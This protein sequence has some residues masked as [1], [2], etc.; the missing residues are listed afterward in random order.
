MIILSIVIEMQSQLTDPFDFINF[1]EC[2]VNRGTEDL[3]NRSHSRFA[4]HFQKGCVL[5][6]SLIPATYIFI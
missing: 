3:T 1:S 4:V 2:L 5:R 6:R